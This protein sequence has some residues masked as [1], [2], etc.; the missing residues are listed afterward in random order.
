MHRIVKEE[1][2]DGKWKENR[3]EEDECGGCDPKLF[4]L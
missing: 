1:F 3:Q 2:F 4:L